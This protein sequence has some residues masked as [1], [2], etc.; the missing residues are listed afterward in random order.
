MMNNSTFDEAL[1]R[2]RGTGSEVAGGPS[3]HPITDRWPP[4]RWSLWD[5]TTTS[6]PGRTDTDR[7]RRQLDALPAAPC[8]ES[9][10]AASR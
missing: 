5:A 10:I 8:A 4:R 7:Y 3:P 9:L 2:L 1:E 6:S